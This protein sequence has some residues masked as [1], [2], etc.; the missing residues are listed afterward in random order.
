M[1]VYVSSD[2]EI[3]QLIAI[4][5]SRNGYVDSQQVYCN[6]EISCKFNITVRNEMMP[7]SRVEVFHLKDSRSMSRVETIIRTQNLG[8]NEVRIRLERQENNHGGGQTP[9][10]FIIL[11]NFHEFFETKNPNPVNCKFL[12]L[13]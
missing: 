9:Y 11:L 10:L 1:T 12:T 2:S 8:I 3:D 6:F 5:T 4:V 13:F 7:E